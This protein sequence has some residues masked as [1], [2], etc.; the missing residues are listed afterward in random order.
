M[1]FPIKLARMS[2]AVLAA[3]SVAFGPAGLALGVARAWAACPC[4]QCAANPTAKSARTWH[5]VETANFRILNFGAEPVA[6][7][8]AQECEAI[9]KRL[10]RQWLGEVGDQAWSRKCVVVLHPNDNSYA[11]EVG[12]AGRNTVASSLVD[13]Q[14]QRVSSRRIDIRVHEAGWHSAALA[15]ELTH[16]ILADRFSAQS[17][18]RWVD[19]G[20]AILA[21][22]TDKQQQHFRELRS[23]MAGGADF[24]VLELFTMADYP[25]A[26]RWGAF[27]GQSASVVQFLVGQTG[28][29]RF[30]QFVELAIS[31]GY[32]EA[33]RDV[34]GFGML[35]LERRWREH[36][37]GN[38]SAVAAAELPADRRGLQ[39]VPVAIEKPLN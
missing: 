17:L 31:Q 5:A 3:W 15:H 39:I 21:D 4:S 35:E 32:D 28:H 23:A 6:Q 29:E 20:L 18:P 2:L 7:Q 27:Y 38:G 13:R 12:A 1:P 10:V 8:A 33:L 24:R 16:V 22:P 11:R 14:R 30:L 19:E 37:R 26:R 25:S 36:V 34:Y 9:R